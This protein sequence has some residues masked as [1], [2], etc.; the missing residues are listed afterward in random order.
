MEILHAGVTTL[1]ILETT[2]KSKVSERANK[3]IIIIMMVVHQIVSQTHSLLLLLLLKNPQPT[4]M[5]A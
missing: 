3:S 5:P 1:D 2:A 4:L